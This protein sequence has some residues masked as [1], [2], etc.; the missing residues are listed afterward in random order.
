MFGRNYYLVATRIKI[1]MKYIK[2]ILVGVACVIASYLI[3]KQ[4]KTY[5]HHDFPDTLVVNNHTE[6]PRIDTVASIVMN[7]IYDIDTVNLDI[8]YMRDISIKGPVEIKAFIQ[9]DE[10][11]NK[12]YNIFIDKDLH[13][14]RDLQKIVSHEIAHLMQ[15]ESGDLY[16]IDTYNY[17]YKEDTVDIREVDYANRGFEKDARKETRK[18][19]KNLKGLLYN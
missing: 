4:D 5:Q 13:S 19:L 12:K 17:V 6:Y 9:K 10:S 14:E 11:R 7:K 18:I 15:Y 2:T 8:I 16:K 3:F 1:F